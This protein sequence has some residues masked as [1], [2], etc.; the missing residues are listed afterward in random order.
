MN[1]KVLSKLYKTALKPEKMIIKD[2]LCKANPFFMR[3]Q[4]WQ[5][6]QHAAQHAGMQAAD[7]AA[8]SAFC[9]V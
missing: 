8:I 4:Y 6:N 5:L 7:L 3:I 1:V 9:R 2:S